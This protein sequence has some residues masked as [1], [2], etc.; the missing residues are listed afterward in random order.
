M[1]TQ[2]YDSIVYFGAE[3]PTIYPDVDTGST[4][5]DGTDEGAPVFEQDERNYKFWLDTD[6]DTLSILRMRETAASAS[7]KA[8][9]N[10]EIVDVLKT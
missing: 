9:V 2:S 3:P 4:T 10:Q 6:N 5:P 7:Y 8:V 1:R